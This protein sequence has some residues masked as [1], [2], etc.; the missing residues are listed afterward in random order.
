MQRVR[1]YFCSFELSGEFAS[2]QDVAEFGPLVGFKPSVSIRRLKI[3]EIKR[4]AAVRVRR[5]I[6]HSPLICGQEPVAQEM[7]HDEVSK[8][9]CGEGEFEAVDCRRAAVEHCAGIVHQDVDAR[10]R[11]GNLSR[12]AFH[13]RKHGKI[14]VMGTMLT[15]RP[16]FT[17]LLERRLGT[18]PVS[19]H[20]HNARAR[21]GE[22]FGGHL[23]DTGRPPGDHDNLILHTKSV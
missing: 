3:A 20:E 16:L 6:D 12:H 18:I 10:F 15:A 7:C 17:E 9:V 13:F 5:R 8:V 21:R 14:S 23:S 11:R 22:M 2:E 1:G 19:R 4:C